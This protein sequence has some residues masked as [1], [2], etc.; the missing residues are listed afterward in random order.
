MFRREENLMK[1]GI[2]LYH[3]QSGYR[4]EV[5][6]D[7]EKLLARVITFINI[8]A[9]NRKATGFLRRMPEFGKSAMRMADAYSQHIHMLSKKAIKLT[10]LEGDIMDPENFIPETS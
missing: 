10:V 9:E 8:D 2:F 4:C 5:F 1:A 6:L 3:D 7:P